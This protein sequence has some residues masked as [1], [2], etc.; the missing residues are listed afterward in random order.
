MSGRMP[1]ALAEGPHFLRGVLRP[2]A[3]GR[4]GRRSWPAGTALACIVFLLATCLPHEWPYGAVADP[5]AG[6]GIHT[7]GPEYPHIR[8]PFTSPI[9]L[10]F[11]MQRR[12]SKIIDDYQLRRKAIFF[13][14]HCARRGGGGPC[15]RL[16]RFI[17]TTCHIL[18][19][20][21]VIKRNYAASSPRHILDTGPFLFA[22]LPDFWAQS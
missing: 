4:G 14:T 5:Y 7:H 3:A 6:G 15:C 18:I 12:L 11:L 22:L 16:N 21:S 10:L 9:I 1:N 17:H 19:A 13:P 2:H 8:L 20:S